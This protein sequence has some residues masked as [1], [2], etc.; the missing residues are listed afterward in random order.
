MLAC[1]AMLATRKRFCSALLLLGLAA[2]S[3]CGP[4]TEPGSTGAAGA[5]LPAPDL[6]GAREVVRERLD[7]ARRDATEALASRRPAPERAA[8]VGRLASLYHAHGYRE[9]ALAAYARA[10]ELEPGAFRWPYLRGLALREEGR[11]DEA[12]EAFERAAELDPDD[13]PVRVRLG[14]LRLETGD[15]AGAGRAYERALALDPDHLAARFGRGRVAAEEGRTGEAVASFRAV[16]ERRPAAGLVRYRLAQALRA[17]GETGEAEALLAEGTE[18]G[19][20]FADPLAEEV[21]RLA[22]GSA[23]EV[24]AAMAED[25]EAMTDEELVGFAVSQFGDV[26]SAVAEL[27]ALADAPPDA[28]GDPAARARL[29]YVVGSLLV[30]RGDAVGAARRLQAALRLDPS[31]EAARNRLATLRDAGDRP[32]QEARWRQVLAE[33]PGDLDARRALAALLGR[34]GRYDE[35]AAEY[36]EVVTARPGDEAAWVGEATALILGGRHR[37]AAARMEEG[38]RALPGSAALTGALARHLVASPDT[39]VRDGERAVELATKAL[40]ADPRL[41]NAETLAMAEAERGRFGQAAAAQRQIL[42]RARAGGAAPAVLE[43]LRRNLERY[44]SGRTCCD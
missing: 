40:V 13:V 34:D 22:R 21:R 7:G 35:A 32:A 8:A 15:L 19:V 41:E 26:E 43:R 20:G 1:A 3:A 37:E 38:V 6:T 33:T 18:G 12:L 39:A 27:A 2:L 17:R 11:L 30:R 4:G 23:V 36:R 16:L 14:D 44:E 24:L 42:D 28:A 5:E 10:E 29:Q 31:L 9:S 25:P